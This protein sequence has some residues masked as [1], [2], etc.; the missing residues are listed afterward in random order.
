MR[1]AAR[2]A[3]A[4]RVSNL[5]EDQSGRRLV[6]LLVVGEVRAELAAVARVHDEVVVVLVPEEV[7]QRDDVVVFEEGHRVDLALEPLLVPRI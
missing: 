5:P 7:L 4:D 3:V 6:Q 1:D 2:V